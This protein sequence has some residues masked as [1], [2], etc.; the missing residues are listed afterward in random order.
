MANTIPAIFNLLS[1]SRKKKVP[2]IAE[3]ATID[4]LFIANTIELLM[5]LLFKAFIKKYRE[6]KFT[7]PSKTPK[8]RVG[9]CLKSS[10]CF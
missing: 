3:K 4:M 10:F 8:T 7:A 6:P 1:F 2:K 9:K 5:L